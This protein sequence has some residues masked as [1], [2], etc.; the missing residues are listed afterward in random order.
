MDTEF[1]LLKEICGIISNY[2]LPFVIV[3]DDIDYILPLID[4]EVL[5]EPKF[6]KPQ[7]LKILLDNKNFDY[8]LIS[9][10]SIL[11]VDYC[12]STKINEIKKIN[13]TKILLEDQRFTLSEDNNYPIRY[14]CFHGYVNIVKLLLEDDKV[15]SSVN[16]NFCIGEAS[17]K[18]YIEIVQLLLN[19]NKVD[20]SDNKN[21]AYKMARIGYNSNP[22][23]RGKRHDDF[24]KI[25]K[26][27]INDQRVFSKYY[28]FR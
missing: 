8:K 13:R 22:L 10:S 4:K 7:L 9:I 12:C 15:D 17:K 27:L 25:E 20:P 28:N 2:Y 6:L 14:A 24:E 19:N 23:Y 11:N 21:Y 1:K 3:C 26:L 18:G 5:Y 16:N